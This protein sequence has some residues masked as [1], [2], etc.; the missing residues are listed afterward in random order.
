MKNYKT[1]ILFII[2]LFFLVFFLPKI[3]EIYR[4]SDYNWIYRLG[5][6][7]TYIFLYINIFLAIWNVIL[8]ILNKESRINKLVFILISLL[9]IYDI[10]YLSIKN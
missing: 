5:I 1:N 7:S 3:V 9:P 10:L 6:F 2:A 4:I 8:I